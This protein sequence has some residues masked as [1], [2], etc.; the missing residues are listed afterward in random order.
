MD[1]SGASWPSAFPVGTRVDMR[2]SFSPDQ[3]NGHYTSSTPRQPLPAQYEPGPVPINS[4]LRWHNLERA[5]RIRSESPQGLAKE[6]V[7]SIEHQLQ[8]P[9]IQDAMLLPSQELGFF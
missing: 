9:R 3:Q 8:M 7:P 1:R 5:F 4:R 6:T 2:M